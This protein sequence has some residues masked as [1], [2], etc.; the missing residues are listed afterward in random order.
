MQT[1]EQDPIQ[2]AFRRG[3]DAFREGKT[4]GDNPYPQDA[5]ANP[6]WDQGFQCE[7]EAVFE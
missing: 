5:A 3:Q 7:Y 4:F 1:P 2:K 6:A